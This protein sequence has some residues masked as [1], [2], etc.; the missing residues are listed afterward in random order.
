VEQH[1]SEFILK[2]IPEESGIFKVGKTKNTTFTHE[3]NGNRAMSDSYRLFFYL[4]VDFRQ[5]VPVHSLAWAM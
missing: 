4:W 5:G 2:Q 3:K 1:V